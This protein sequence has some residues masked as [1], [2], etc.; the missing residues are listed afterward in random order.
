MGGISQA[1]SSAEKSAA[2]IVDNIGNTISQD[3]SGNKQTASPVQTQNSNPR[4]QNQT[5]TAA[6]PP[7]LLL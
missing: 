6:L 7:P 2:N 5:A 4:V 3:L 1:L